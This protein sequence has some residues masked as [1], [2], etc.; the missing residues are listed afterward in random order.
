MTTMQCQ[1]VPFQH[2]AVEEEV[3][4]DEDDDARVVQHDV[5]NTHHQANM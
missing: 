4:H 1:R 5:T 2:E 3:H